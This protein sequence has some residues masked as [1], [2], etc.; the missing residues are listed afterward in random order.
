MFEFFNS[1]I[2]WIQV[3]VNYL[4]SFF[5]FLITFITMIPKGLGWLV[6]MFGYLPAFVS[7]FAVT[8]VVISIVLQIMNKGS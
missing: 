2:D 4:V 5:K 7:A 8:F 3:L 1:I 6:L